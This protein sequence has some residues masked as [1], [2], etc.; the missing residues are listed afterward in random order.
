MVSCQF[1]VSSDWSRLAGNCHNNKQV[2]RRIP[3]QPHQ[4][5]RFKDDSKTN[6]A[7]FLTGPNAFSLHMRHPYAWYSWK[8]QHKYLDHIVGWQYTQTST[9]IKGFS[10]IIV[11]LPIPEFHLKFMDQIRMQNRD[12]QSF[13]IVVQRLYSVLYHPH[14][15]PTGLWRIT[16]DSSQRD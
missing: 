2:Y 12:V 5:T 10:S 7:F 1:F 15:I 9:Y 11:L 13:H 16:C 3:M 14:G 6:D 4:P 8:C